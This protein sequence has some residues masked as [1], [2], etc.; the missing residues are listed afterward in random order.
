MTR[1]LIQNF[2]GIRGVVLHRADRSRTVLTGTLTRLGLKIDA[3]DPLDGAA[4]VRDAVKDAQLI[5]FDADFVETVVL[6]WAGDP[7]LVPLIAIVGLEAPGRL[8]R[9]F[10]LEPA[11]VIH[12]PLRSTGIYSTVFFA[13]NEHRRRQ[14]LAQKLRELEDRHRGRRFVTRA[15]V[16]M[17]ALRHVYGRRHRIL[18]PGGCSLRIIVVVV[19][20]DQQRHHPVRFGLLDAGDHLAEFR[21]RERNELLANDVA[22]DEWREGLGPG[23][24]QLPEII[25]RRNRIATDERSGGLKIDGSKTSK[26]PDPTGTGRTHPFEHVA[27]ICGRR[28]RRR[29]CGSA[30][31]VSLQSIIHCCSLLAGH[32][33]RAFVAVRAWSV[34]RNCTA[35]SSIVSRRRMLSL[36]SRRYAAVFLEPGTHHCAHY[37]RLAV[38]D[39]NHDVKFV[40]EWPSIQAWWLQRLGVN[41][42]RNPEYKQ[43]TPDEDPYFKMFLKKS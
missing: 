34:A 15:I 43:Y 42:V 12:K 18:E 24:G 28:R 9:A 36:R 16:Q 31:V 22:A 23:G 5:L 38:C 39:D 2:R 6:S 10:E 3:A 26:T 1:P 19:L 32:A 21:H 8:L 13:V 20:A 4:V 11:A 41:L 30:V 37:I 7:V 25:V 14:D 29:W 35:N 40:R 17:I 33:S 27:A